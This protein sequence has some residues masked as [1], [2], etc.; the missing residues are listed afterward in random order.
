MIGAQN[1]A[2][3][4]WSPKLVAAMNVP[5]RSDR[6]VSRDVGGETFVVPVRSGVANLEAIF[7]L[8][9]VGSAIWAQIDGKKTVADL[10]RAI[11]A[12]FDVSE[13]EATADVTAFVD[14]LASKGLIEE[15]GVSK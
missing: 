4:A 5:R 6:F 8:N 11:T 12:E 9:G 14:L 3:P 15:A 2:A 10:A 1:L 13:A 7:T